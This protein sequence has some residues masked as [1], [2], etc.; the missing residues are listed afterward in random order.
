[1][2]N[3]IDW[4]S[5]YPI[6]NW[7]GYNWCQDMPDGDKMHPH[8]PYRYYHSDAVIQSNDD[9]RLSVFIRPQK[10][11]RWDGKVYDSK[12]ACGLLRSEECFTYGMYTLEC[13]LPKGRNLLPAFWL[14]NEKTWPPEIDIFEGYPNIFGGYWTPSIRPHKPLLKQGYAIEPNIHY[15]TTEDR[16]KVGANGVEMNVLHNPASEVNKYYLEWTPDY[17]LIRYNNT[18]VKYIDKRTNF[19][20]F[21]QLNEHPWMYVI[22][23]NVIHKS[24]ICT[25]GAEL[26]LKHFNY[27]KL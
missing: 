13:I 17:I 19:K 9:I 15:G 2:N 8:N 12:Y 4:T 14:T 10:V 24:G 23:D 3:I 18:I 7:M 26:I 16:I 27:R 1:M 5:K 6:L 21:Q 11:K 22:F 20:L 25:I